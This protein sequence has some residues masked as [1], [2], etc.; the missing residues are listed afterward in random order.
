MCPSDTQPLGP[1]QAAALPVE[2][3]AQPGQSN[4]RHP[5][6]VRTNPGH[7]A[8]SATCLSLIIAANQSQL[9][10]RSSPS[11]RPRSATG[12]RP[13][14]RSGGHPTPFH[15]LNRPLRP[16]R[17]PGLTPP[18]LVNRTR[19]GNPLPQVAAPSGG[20]PPGLPHGKQRADTRYPAGGHDHRRG[21]SG[22]KRYRSPPGP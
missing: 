4:R 12:D 5:T 22:G 3:A 16:T 20:E 8:R 11:P 6:L 2:A 14:R 15:D 1:S 13:A 21:P 18:R 9:P 17:W 7:P 19:H 10:A